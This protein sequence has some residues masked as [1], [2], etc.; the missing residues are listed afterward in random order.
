MNPELHPLKTWFRAMAMVLVA[1]LI[2]ILPWPGLW[3]WWQPQWVL[4]VL[5][6][7]HFRLPSHVQIFTAFG[8][9]V[10]FD[11]LVGPI[12]G[13]HALIFSIC[14]FLTLKMSQKMHLLWAWQEMLWVTIMVSLALAVQYWIF[15]LLGEIPDTPYFWAPI[16][17]SM[18]I[19]IPLS[20]LLDAYVSKYLNWI[21]QS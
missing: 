13:M 12:M 5:L 2:S 14:A 17:S 4:L 19:W 18:I 9:G 11:V 8:M 7:W 1:M 21:R 15:A 3:L 10:W 16:V 20:V 6:Y